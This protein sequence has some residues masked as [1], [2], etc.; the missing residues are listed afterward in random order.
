MRGGP[1]WRQAGVSSQPTGG[2][3]TNSGLD[4]FRPFA[5][6]YTQI[7]T[8]TPAHIDA[9]RDERLTEKNSRGRPISPRN[10]NYEVATIRSFYYKLFQ[11]PV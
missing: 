1:D 4:Y 6:S 7:G 3:K 10:I 8:I 11:N 9:F 5:K 2:Q